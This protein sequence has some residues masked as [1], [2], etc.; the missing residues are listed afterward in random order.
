MIKA[1][2][3]PLWL[4]ILGA[5]LT[6]QLLVLLAL[7]YTS[8]TLLNQALLQQNEVRV[9]ELRPLLNANLSGALFQRDLAGI[10]TLLRA[11]QRKQGIS[12]LWLVDADGKF[13]AAAGQVPAAFQ[14][15]PQVK[16]VM[17]G[18]IDNEL[19]VEIG[20]I[21]Y[22]TL[23]F[24]LSTELA[25]R[26]KQ[27]LI[28][29]GFLVASVTEIIAFLLL[30]VMSIW[31]TRHLRQLAA[32]SQSLAAGGE[33][34]KLPVNTDDEVGQLNAAFNAMAESLQQ[35]IGAL[36]D[37]ETRQ[38]EALEYVREEEARLVALLSAMTL[39]IVFVD[40][41][42]RVIYCNPAFEQIWG[43]RDR[44]QIIGKSALDLLQHS[45]AVL[46][47]PAHFSEYMVRMMRAGSGMTEF[48]IEMVGGRLVTQV[49]RSVLA[50]DGQVLGSLWIFEDVTR[51]RQTAAQLLYLAE[52][53]ALTGL[54][55]RRSFENALSGI[56]RSNARQEQ[57]GALLFIDLDGFKYINDTFGHRAGDAMLIRVSGVIAALVRQGEVLYRLGGDEFAILMPNVSDTDAQA[58]ATRVVNAIAQIPFRF[59][60]RDLRLTSSVGIAL[61]P[62]HANDPDQLV[63]RADAAMYQ[64]KQAGKNSWRSYQENLDSSREMVSRMQWSQRIDQALNEQLFELHF[65]GVYI[66]ATGLLSHYEV[67]IRMRESADSTEFAMPGLFVAIAEQSGQILAIDRWVLTESLQMLA[68]HP[69][70]PALAV[71][72]SGRSLDDAGLI[73]F[74]AEQ[75]EL[76]QVDHRRLMFEITETAALSDLQD[77][78]RFIEALREMG[79]MVSL[80]DFGN[81]FSSFA[82]LKY[83]NANMLKIDGMFIQNICDEMDNQIFVK[84]IV[85]V[86][87]GLGK[88]TVA[89]CVETQDVFDMVKKLG[90]DMVQGYYFDRPG[91]AI[92]FSSK[93]L[94]SV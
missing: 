59:E 90:V 48:E 81:G 35:R 22:G 92:V 39:G 61:Y 87:R 17:S 66:V 25:E 73:D 1:V 33:H 13:I 28:E 60:E 15:V 19:P 42:G 55:N 58:L 93:H 21:R 71:N 57:K 62:V 83:L 37:A 7:G 75:L 3:F 26:A 23:H 70:V 12:Y 63:A 9:N 50:D 30:L 89:E 82:Y 6:V 46:V 69:E 24:G 88:I 51:E 29:Q 86:A 67:L 11:V 40:K 27:R 5:A 45:N 4:K 80:D 72:L 14:A 77:A 2:H 43:L 8:I 16:P 53:D 64:A 36:Q 85:D 54:Y 79:C 74:I 10:R 34:I 20:G 78:Q 47:N 76:Y 18:I 49:T 68:K 32:A 31:L 52:R 65:Q 38:R 84:A 44:E 91:P 94:R 41:A 56:F